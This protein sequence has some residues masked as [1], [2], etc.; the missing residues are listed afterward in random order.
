MDVS[1]LALSCLALL[2]AA[3]ACT[4]AEAKKADDFPLADAQECRARGGL[5]NFFAKLDAG[6]EVRIGYLGGS[7][8]EQNGWRPKTLKWFQD[9]YPKAKISEINASIGGTGSDLG[10]YRL[11]HDVLRHKPDLLFV[12]FAVNDGGAAPDQI[13]R[14]MEGIVLQ[15]WKAD[16]TTDICFVYTFVAGWAKELQDGKFPRAASVMEKLADFYGIPSIHM[17]LETARMAK[18]GKVV[19]QAKKPK[20]DEEKKALEGKI[21]FSEDGVHPLPEG[22]ELY[23]AAVVRSMP[24]IK[25]AG[26]VGPHELAKPLV[27]DNMAAAKFIP[28]DK[29]KLGEGWEKLPAENHLVKA[30]GNRLGDLWHTAKPGTTVTF[31]FK[32]T[33]AAIYDLLG[34]DCGQVI[35]TLDDQPPRTVPRFDRY[36][37]Y[38]RLA[39]LWIGGPLPDAVHTVK[40]ELSPDSPDKAKLLKEG[41]LKNENPDDP[42]YKGISWYAGGILIVGDVTD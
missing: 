22:H 28:L 42:K 20:T 25:A 14:A 35:V 34:P 39:T 17:G 13:L 9:Q 6:Q 21:L 37:N 31:K 19:L 7:I 36:C 2:L 27:A 23:L 41:D 16:P 26:K 40:L 10:V 24:A 18:E 38:D 15:T 30:F 29:A 1:H 5:P 32:G 11:E 12:E 4:A 3:T 8:T 33:A